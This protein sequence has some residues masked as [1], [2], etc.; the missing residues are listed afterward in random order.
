MTDET[1]ILV[2][3]DMEINR[4]ILRML[5]E[6]ECKV[7]EAGD[8]QQ[9]LDCLAKHPKIDLVILD[10]VMP[11]M[12]GFETLAAIRQQRSLAHLPVIICTEHADVDVQVR[13]LDLGSSDFITKPFNARVVRHRVRNLI[14]MREMERK[15]AEQQKA[16]QLRNTLNSIVSPLGLFEF[17][18]DRMR[19]LYLNQNLSELFENIDRKPKSQ[20]QDLLKLMLPEDANLLVNLLN[21]NL[22]NGTPVDMTYHTARKDGITATHE[23]HALSIR[24]ENDQNPVYLTSIADI[25]DQRR[26]EVAL[27]DTDQRLK[28]LVN[29]VPGAI[30]NFDMTQSPRVTFFN[31]TACDIVKLTRAEFQTLTAKDILGFVCP[32]DRHILR[33][34]IDDFKQNPRTLGEAFRIVRKDGEV[35][36]L[37]TSIAPI[38]TVDDSLLSS[39]VCTDVTLEKEAGLKLEKAFQQMKYRSEH[40]LLTDL[41]NR[42]TFNQ[43]VQEMLQ[44]KASIPYVMLAINIQRF[45]MIN[46]F[47]G[48]DIGDQVLITLSRC[49]DRLFSPM[50]ICGRM[51][52]DHFMACLPKAELDMDQVTE[53]LDSELKARYTD[54][55]IGVLF[56]IYEIRDRTIATDQM[57]DRAT[58]ALKSISGSAVKRFAVYDDVMRET[59]VA[60]QGIIEEMYDALQQGQ[61]IPYLQPIYALSTLKPVSAEV[62][63]RWKHPTKGMISPATFIPL[64]ERNGF[65]TK[66]DYV[67]WEHACALL[68]KWKVN[69]MPLLPLSINISRIDLYYPYLCEDLLS[70]IKKYDLDPSLLKLEITESAY[71]DDP[72]VLMGVL[73]RLRAAGFRILMD[74][75]GSGYSSLNT[76]KDMPINVLKVDMSFLAALEDSPRAS[77]I[78]T[79]VVRMAKWLDLPVIA[80]GVETKEQLDFLYSIGCDDGQGYLF[81]RPIPVSEFELLLKEA[82]GER[83]DKRVRPIPA[84][85]LDFLWQDNMDV[86]LLFANMIGGMALFELQSDM[87]VAN[88][89]NDAYY[90]VLNC[91]PQKVFRSNPNA[92]DAI[93]PDDRLLVLEAC[94]AAIHSHRVECV[95]VREKGASLKQ[96][97][98]E[99]KVYHLASDRDN[100]L[101]LVIINEAV[102]TN[103]TSEY[104][105]LS[106]R[107]SLQNIADYIL[108]GL[109]LF[110]IKDEKLKILYLNNA[111]LRMLGYGEGDLPDFSGEFLTTLYPGNEAELRK[112]IT[113]NES[114]RKPVDI[115]YKTFRKDTSPAWFRAQIRFISQA[116]DKSPILLASITDVEKEVELGEKL[117]NEQCFREIFLSEALFVF[118]Y[119]IETQEYQLLYAEENAAEQYGSFERYTLL[120][121]DNY[122]VHP[123]DQLTVQCFFDPKHLQS[124]RRNGEERGKIEAR[125]QNLLSEWVWVEI[126]AYRPNEEG[127]KKRLLFCIKAVDRQKRIEA[128][129]LRRAEIDP[130]S[131]LLNRRATQ[132]RIVHT[133]TENHECCNAFFLLDIDNFKNVNDTYGHMIGDKVILATSKVLRKCFRSTDLVGRFGGDEFVVFM[134]YPGGD[135]LVRAKAEMVLSSIR[136]LSFPGNPNIKLTVS[137]GIALTP[138]EDTELDFDELYKQA[139]EALY[140]IKA[141]GKNGYRIYG[142]PRASDDSSKGEESSEK[143]AG[144]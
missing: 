97:W 118:G 89:V 70:L 33:Q 75:F 85:D 142:D 39:C 140:D 4:V 2:V 24:Y 30:I 6:Q 37:H 124:L 56:G 135:A 128:D 28:S 21:G 136:D 91:T 125:I 11:V 62:L 26:T 59:L 92:L 65:V 69:N 68:H 76:L 36:W 126:S 51:E 5:F 41:W 27:R 83:T 121:G 117:Q 139:D 47:F 110:E 43:K 129:L 87:L 119:D 53:M 1:T 10:I 98:L 78:L 144:V 74:D 14:E 35:R 22:E 86:N 42:E 17:T 122:T 63:V 40:D 71:I 96:R 67:V 95:V 81:S 66:L 9:A 82:T 46:D 54:Y 16:D 13:A 49:M 133:L 52:A 29:A 100:P 103:E 8:G 90:Q 132:E 112:V 143:D 25:T 80:E 57:C 44:D 58:L 38:N 73:K 93:E 61:F 7:L 3:D 99:H 64:F 108:V 34:L 113:K 127:Q 79:S 105:A 101:F 50:G 20:D 88:R 60:E 102:H 12:D 109:G 141:H 120:Y 18:G 48:A 31:D 106:I 116:D 84:C 138:A 45:K 131:K 94:H 15:I 123:D 115:R 23:L 77:S 19:S 111:Y 130:V 134:S 114:N 104:R 55:H 32:D 72:E 137:L 107:Q